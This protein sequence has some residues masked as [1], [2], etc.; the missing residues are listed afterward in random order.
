MPHSPRALLRT[1]SAFALL[2]CVAQVCVAR[3]QEPQRHELR[4]TYAKDAVTWHRMSSDMAMQMDMGG[5]KIDMQVSIEMTMHTKVVELLADGSAKVERTVKRLQTK[6]ENPMMGE[7]VYDSDV[8]DA[9]AGQMADMAVLVGVKM[10]M[11][12]DRRGKVKSLKFP[13]ELEDKLSGQMNVED[14]EGMFSKESIVLPEQPVAIGETW[15]AE[16]SMP[17][18]GGM[19]EVKM[20]QENKLISYE[21][22]VAIIDQ[23]VSFGEAQEMQSPK[24]GPMKITGHPAQGKV[25]LNLAA[26]RPE[27]TSTKM[28]LE[29]K[30][31]GIDMSIDMDL[32]LVRIEEPKPAGTPSGGEPAPKKEGGGL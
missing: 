15:K 22:G 28:K 19:G 16:N 20:F 29:M 24:G 30:G 11:Q 6:L 10:T 14:L 12:M 31:D 25:E 32:E 2:V 21:N 27:K 18:G 26:G 3:A 13:P 1:T 23:K 7:H 4:F 9:D 17:L 5:Q 8:K